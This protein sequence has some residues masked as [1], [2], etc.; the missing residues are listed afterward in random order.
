MTFEESSAKQWY[1]SPSDEVSQGDIVQVSPY[2]MIDA[3][4]TICQPY[5]ADEEGKAKYAPLSKLTIRRGVEFLHARFKIAHG[6]VLWPDCQI[7]KGKNQNKPEREWFAAVA[8]IISLAVLPEVEVRQKVMNF[9]RAQ[10]F[11]LPAHPPELL[12]SYVDLRYV[13]PLKYSLLKDRVLSL[14]E[15]ARRALCL[16]RFWFDTE[17][18]LREDVRCP[19]CEKVVPV[20]LMFASEEEKPERE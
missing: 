6:L 1:D 9:E 17:M 19:H 5:N 20:S 8:P 10:W 4:L 11:P 18:R 13:W 14:S 12:E 3:P 2:G 15:S 16:H 7:D